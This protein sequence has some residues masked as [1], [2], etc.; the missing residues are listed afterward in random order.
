MRGDWQLEFA[1]DTGDNLQR[2][3]LRRPACAIRACDEARLELGEVLDVV[4]KIRN[5]LLSFG[6]EQLERQAKLAGAVGGG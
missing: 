2:E 3:V 4:E 1:M 5:A 6:R